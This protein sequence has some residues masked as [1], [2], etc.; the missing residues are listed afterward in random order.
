MTRLLLLLA[1][2]TQTAGVPGTPPQRTQRLPLQKNKLVF[3]SPATYQKRILRYDSKTREPIYYDPKPQVALLDLKSGKYALRWI[4]YDG[5]EKTVIFQRAAAIDAIVTASVSRTASGQYVYTY[6][7]KNLT[8]SGEHL[9]IF[10][11]QNY[12]SKVSPIKNSNLYVGGITKNAR[13]FKDGNWLGFGLLTPNIVPGETIELKLVSDGQPGLVECRVA[14]G[15]QGMKGVG[16]EM[17][18]E[19]ENVLPGYK[20][21][22]SGY[23]VGPVDYLK[24]LGSSERAK[25]LLE[26][27]PLFLKLGWMTSVAFQGYQQS[28]GR[29]DIQQVKNRAEQDFKTGKITTEV[30]DMIHAIQ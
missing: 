19:L 24:Y 4:G 29:G 11:V 17:P 8:S 15:E 28:L 25:Y 23:T 18:Q 22:P 16:E 12:S 13:E 6:D 21:W 14:G 10:A 30:Y 5:K 1:L 27:L 7:I 3:K 20:D 26:R 2:V 9:S